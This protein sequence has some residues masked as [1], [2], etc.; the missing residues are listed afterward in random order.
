MVTSAPI[1]VK[2]FGN[3]SSARERCAVNGA[4]G[5]AADAAFAVDLVKPRVH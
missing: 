4:D 3:L 2:P 1:M 5:G